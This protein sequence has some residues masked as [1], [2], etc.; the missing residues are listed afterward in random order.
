MSVTVRRDERGVLTL[1]LDRPG[2]RNAIDDAMAAALIAELAAAATDD[3]VRVVLLQGA[4]ADFCSGADIVARNAA[5][6]ARPRTGS[7]QRRLP[8]A[9]HRLVTLVTTIQVPV[10]CKVRGWAAGLG[11]QLALAADF[12]VCA[13]DARLWEPFARRGF[14]PDSG[15]TWLLPRR[16]G[17]V[18][19]RE[20]LLLGRE[21]SGA[22]AADWGAVHAAVPEAELDATVDD[23]VARLA[24]GPTVTLGL[25][26]QLLREG[27]GSGLDE[28]LRREALALELSSRSEDF[29][30]GMAAF[31]ERRDPR[32]GGR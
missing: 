21:L 7:I 13:E 1:T 20:L 30:E 8:E 28:Q 24:A 14:T 6:G 23:L 12:A 18:R 32:F 26:K 2:A 22:E 17:E 16:V 5:E 11:F 25:T 9:A 15:A 3:T 27:A 31:R 10:V 29:R 19:A 4:G